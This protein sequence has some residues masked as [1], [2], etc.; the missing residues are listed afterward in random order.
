MTLVKSRTVVGNLGFLAN[1]MSTRK[2]SLGQTAAGRYLHVIYAPD[3]EGEGVF[4]VTAYE[5]LGKPLRAYRR[6][7][8]RR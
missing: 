5:I 4:V 2:F 1:V 8:N 6:R 3:E 7:R